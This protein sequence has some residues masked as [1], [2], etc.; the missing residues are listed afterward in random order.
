[1]GDPGGSDYIYSPW[2]NYPEKSQIVT[3]KKLKKSGENKWGIEWSD[4]SLAMLAALI[5][6]LIVIIIK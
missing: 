4:L 5:V 6:G 1:M 3:V 2:I